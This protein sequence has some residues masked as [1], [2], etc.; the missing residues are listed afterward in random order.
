MLCEPGIILAHAQ[1]AGL[2]L[3]RQGDTLQVRGQP[4]AE[5]QAL[6]RQYK[7]MLLPLLPPEPEE[8]PPPAQAAVTAYALRRLPAWQ[9]SG[10]V[11][12]TLDMF[13]PDA[14]LPHQPVKSKPAKPEEARRRINTGVALLLIAG[15]GSGITREIEHVE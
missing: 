10:R 2:G 13:G 1:R 15:Y 6:L 7:P 14:T 11:G 5:W 9:P 4:S 8:P 3:T 12:E